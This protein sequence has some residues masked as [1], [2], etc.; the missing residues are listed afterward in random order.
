MG[1][2]I[3]MILTI[4]VGLSVT[5]FLIWY[6]FVR[7]TSSPS[8]PPSP[9]PCGDIVTCSKSGKICLSGSCVSNLSGNVL[10]DT[11]A[12]FPPGA[13]VTLLS[14]SSQKLIV[15][16]RLQEGK[17]QVNVL[18]QTDPSQANQ[19]TSLWQVVPSVWIKGSVNLVSK[20][21]T[22]LQIADPG[23]SGATNLHQNARTF[24]NIWTSIMAITSSNAGKTT[25]DLRL[26]G[27]NAAANGIGSS[28][29]GFKLNSTP[30]SSS[31]TPVYGWTSDGVGLNT[32]EDGEANPVVLSDVQASI[33][34]TIQKLW[35][36]S[37]RLDSFPRIVWMWDTENPIVAIWSENA[38]AYLTRSSNNGT[39]LANVKTITKSFDADNIQ[40]W[41]WRLRTAGNDDANFPGSFFFADPTDVSSL[42]FLN[43]NA[44]DGSPSLKMTAAFTNKAFLYLTPVSESQNDLYRLMSPALAKKNDPS[45]DLDS[46]S[47]PMDFDDDEIGFWGIGT[48]G[49]VPVVPNFPTK[50]D[51]STEFRIDIINYGIKS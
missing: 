10:D 6:F 15:A 5:A 8:P 19:I 47:E 20:D 26:L 29:P 2:K 22:F 45:L 32:V 43:L 44:S 4:V 34:V 49:A 50:S 7:D 18:A 28:T 24:S 46:W 27:V 30:V 13:F 9:P 14:N 36:M 33:Q 38:N 31:T 21:S 17:S 37:P 11:Q 39:I 23:S 35:T 51:S 12:I 16:D 1:K 48:D 40:P 3:P 42:L 25:K 41:Q